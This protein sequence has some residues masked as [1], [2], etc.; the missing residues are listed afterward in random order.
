MAVGKLAWEQLMESL[1]ILVLGLIAVVFFLPIASIISVNRLKER[2]DA[3]TREVDSLKA[4]LGGVGIAAAPEP[5]LDDV[6]PAADLPPPEPAGPG[7]ASDGPG[8]Q[9]ST[10][11]ASGHRRSVEQTL[12]TRW[13]VWVGGLALALGGVFLVKYSIE[14]GLLGPGVRVLLGALFAAA[15]AAAGEFLRRREIGE[16]VA[17]VPGAYIPGALTAAAILSAFATVYAAYALYEFLPPVAAFILLAAVSVASLSISWLH[18]PGLAGLGLVGSYATPLLVASQAPNAWPLFLYL[19]FVTAASFFVARLRGWLWLA[20]SATAG[21]VLWGLIW[22]GGSWSPDDITPLGF[23]ILALT[24][25][26]FG[27]LAYGSPEKNGEVETG[28]SLREL[29]AGAD[30]IVTGILAAVTLL[31][32]PAI[33]LD[34]YGTESLLLMCA[35]TITLLTGA[36]YWRNLCTLIVWAAILFATVYGTWHLPVLLPEPVGPFD[37]YMGLPQ[38]LPPEIQV[39]LCIG[40]AFGALFAAA[41]F[42]NALAARSHAFWVI[43]SAAMPILIFAYAYLRATGFT[44][45][46]PFATAGLSLA[47]GYVAA[48]EIMYRNGNV[49]P[50]GWRSGCYAAAAVVALALACTIALDKGWLTIALALICPGLGWVALNRPVPGLRYLAAGMAAVVIARLVWDPLIA[51]D[52]VGATAVFNWLL[53]GYGVPAVAFAAASIMFRQQRDDR[54]VQILEAASILC[55]VI[56]VGLQIRHLLNDGDVYSDVF[57]LFE[58]SI[59]SI[60]LLG[61]TIGLQRLYDRTGRPVVEKASAILGCIGL[62]AMLLGHLLL[63]NPLFTNESIGQGR[64]FNLLMLAYLVPAILCGV[65]YY[66]SRGRHRHYLAAI[67]GTALLL[68]LAWLTLENRALFQGE[69]LANGA[70]G[71]AEWYAYS[72]IWLLYGAALLAGGIF[73]GIPALRYASLAIILL[74]VGK[75]FLSDMENLEGILRALSF[76]GLGAVLIGVGYFYQRYVFPRPAAG[77][78]E[79]GLGSPQN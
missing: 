52:A 29:V 65:L 37:A 21:A 51:G 77:G 24:G 76:I 35:V 10:G 61:L 49:H 12:G 45:D 7:G 66:M 25:I 26:G 23:Y 48:S 78:D 16:S 55:L 17:G 39:F 18:G 3:L 11:A 22:C 46:L 5:P 40:A 63:F 2:V 8:I 56:L 58:L 41:G 4:R 71:D 62:A 44:Q 28:T 30:W 9:L 38:Q 32:L 54:V 69:T 31:V 19:L 36:W 13:T 79:A 70:T 60:S 68:V 53:Y 34:G 64:V 73:T 15:L 47:L 75:V 67:G 42:Y 72:A 59:Q 57:D 33:R 6:V 20:M 1:A 74:S 27:F 14:A 50:W 43:V